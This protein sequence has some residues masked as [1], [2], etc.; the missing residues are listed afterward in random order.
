MKHSQTIGFI[1]ALLVIGLCFL[2]WS[3]VESRQLTI[4]G[5]H[6]EGTSF[7]KPGLFNIIICSIMALLFLVPRIWAKRTNVFIGA[8]NLAWSVRNYLLVSACMMG[9]CP[10]KKPALYSIVFLSLLMQF[11]AFFPKIKLPVKPSV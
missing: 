6:A 1:A 10:V 2:P 11:M 3:Y 7:G 8:L 9:E 4:S 5:I